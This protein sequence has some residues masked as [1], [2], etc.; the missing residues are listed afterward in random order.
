MKSGKNCSRS[1]LENILRKSRLIG[2]FPG[3]SRSDKSTLAR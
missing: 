2:E 1:D 3:L